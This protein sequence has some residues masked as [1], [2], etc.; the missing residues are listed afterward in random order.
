MGLKE[1]RVRAS[2]TRDLQE[3]RVKR[4]RDAV[5]D[6]VNSSSFVLSAAEHANEDVNK[7]A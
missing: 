5:V 7:L 6:V 1:L 4:I 2:S 3:V